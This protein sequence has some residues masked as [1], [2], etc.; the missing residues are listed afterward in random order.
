MKSGVWGYFF[1]LSRISFHIL[2]HLW[3]EWEESSVCH[4]RLRMDST[5]FCQIMLIGIIKE[6]TGGSIHRYF[7]R[8]C[9]N[10]SWK[11]W[12][13]ADRQRRRNNWKNL[14]FVF[15]MIVSDVLWCIQY[16]N[17]FTIILEYLFIT[18][19]PADDAQNLNCSW[20]TAIKNTF[21]GSHP[22]SKSKNTFLKHH[23][24]FIKSKHSSSK[25]KIDETLS[26]R[27]KEPGSRVPCAQNWVFWPHVHLLGNRDPLTTKI[28]CYEIKKCKVLNIWN[29]VNP[30]GWV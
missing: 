28:H 22:S 11:I 3:N 4:S 19:L 17:R 18:I 29:I 10:L 15:C 27:W 26:W 16:T 5:K 24:V 25:S 23:L 6:T 30:R 13:G 12:V 2:I 20:H 7:P 9:T 14:R 1:L 8:K 21:W